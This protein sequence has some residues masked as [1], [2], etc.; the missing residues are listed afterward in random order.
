MA[1]D[2]DEAVG[3][4]RS[5]PQGFGNFLTA[6]AAIRALP[7]AYLIDGQGKVLATA[8]S[9]PEFPYRAPPKEAMELAKK[10]QVIVIAPGQTSLVGAIK[11]LDNFNDT[12]LYVIRPVN[13]RVLRPD[14]CGDRADASALGHLDRHVVRQPPSG[15]DPPA[16][17]RR[18]GN[19]PRQS[20]CAR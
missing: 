6:Q 3:L 8:A 11:S 17:G 14:V 19:Q 16:D 12:Y 13:A 18:R 4:V 5:Q 15:A 9:M 10:G 2:I 1:K 7:M 20:R